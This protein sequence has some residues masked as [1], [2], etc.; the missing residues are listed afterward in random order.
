ML[1][2]LGIDT[3]L[4]VGAHEGEWAAALRRLGYAG[5]IISYEPVGSLYRTLA[6]RSA[7][8]GAWK[9]VNA[10]VGR[11][12]STASLA[13]RRNTMMSS[14]RPIAMVPDSHRD[15][16]AVVARETVRVVRLEDEWPGGRVMLKVDT[17]GFD[18]EVLAGCGSRLDE[19]LAV[20]IEL[21]FQPTYEGQPDYLKALGALDAWGFKPAGFIP[22]WWDGDGRLLEGDCLL[23]R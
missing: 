23:C 4:D 12:S 22:L 2:R 16:V 21:G 6:K 15:Q 17:Q 8:D 10:A 11:E 18:L 14:L 5:R 13:V 1:T 19:V 9:A 7:A 3:L 20:Q